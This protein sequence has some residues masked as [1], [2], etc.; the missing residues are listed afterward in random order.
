[1]SDIIHP[2]STLSEDDLLELKNLDRGLQSVKSYEFYKATD[3][4]HV[5]AKFIEDAFSEDKKLSKGDYLYLKGVW[6]SF[7]DLKDSW[8]KI[9]AEVANLGLVGKVT[10]AVK[11]Y[12]AFK[13]LSAAIK[14][15]KDDKK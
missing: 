2:E 4:A 1:M 13:A 8:S 6:E 9:S 3:F 15:A 5:L 11:G 7:F 10:L 12:G 14:K